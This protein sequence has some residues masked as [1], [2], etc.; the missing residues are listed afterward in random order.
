MIK[1]RN[2]IIIHLFLLNDH[3]SLGIL[4]LLESIDLRLHLLELQ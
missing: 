1:T 3:V 4:L 2:I